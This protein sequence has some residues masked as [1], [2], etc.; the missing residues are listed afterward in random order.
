MLLY[1][2][3]DWVSE[4]GGH[5]ELYGGD[6]DT[7]NYSEIKSIEP[8]FN[9]LVLFECTDRSWHAVQ[10]ILSK[11]EFTRKVIGLFYL[12][13]SKLSNGNLRAR[14]APRENQLTDKSIAEMI[15]KREAQG[16]KVINKT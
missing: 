3:E 13:D 14:Y 10:P 5:L 4:Y 8:T 11:D 15:L 6:R 16:C 7:P 2:S 1:M 9:R 12:K